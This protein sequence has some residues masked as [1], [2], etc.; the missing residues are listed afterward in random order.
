MKYPR[1]ALALCLA[2]VTVSCNQ[3]RTPPTDAE[4]LTVFKEHKA[5]FETLQSM[6]CKD[7]YKTISMDPEWSKPAN[8]PQG[9][10][11]SYY[12]LFRKIGVTQLQS[13][14]GCRA[15]FSVWALGWAGDAD[16]KNYR[17]RPEKPEKLVQ[18]LDKLPLN[19]TDIAFFY[20][21]IEGEW[22]LEYAHWP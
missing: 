11:S 22:Y 7:G 10:K 9:K 3:S 20:R 14:D 2:L 21:H 16:Y 5:T 15:Q 17:Y 6:I 19:N 4:M 13:Y 12:Q 8:I 1:L 18:S